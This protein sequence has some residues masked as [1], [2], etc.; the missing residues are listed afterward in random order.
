MNQ[1]IPLSAER[2]DALECGVKDLES[3]VKDLT[4]RMDRF[5][6]RM[7]AMEDTIVARL[8]DIFRVLDVHSAILHRLDR[9]MAS[10]SGRVDVHDRMLAGH[11]D[12][13]SR[14]ERNIA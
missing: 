1:S 9:D 5:E 8:D 3:G 10:V 13:I 7:N 2:L 6:G 11:A 4:V 12:R 14:L